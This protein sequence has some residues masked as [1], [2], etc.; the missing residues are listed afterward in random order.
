MSKKI[1]IDNIKSL[2]NVENSELL[3]GISLPP[4]YQCPEIDKIISSLRDCEKE[5]NSITKY[6][7]VG[8]CQSSA[9]DIEWDLSSIQSDIEKLR[10]E[11]EKLRSWGEEWKELAKTLIG[12]NPNILLSVV[13]DVLYEKVENYLNETEVH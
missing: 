1:D 6:D 4:K 8:D 2:C 3:F 9:S 5:A 13:K 7:D 10:K 11:I 12:H